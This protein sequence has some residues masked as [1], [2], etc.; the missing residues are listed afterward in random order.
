[1]GQVQA[2]Q[3]PP[4]VDAGDILE[5]RNRFVLADLPDNCALLCHKSECATGPRDLFHIGFCFRPECF[6]Q[7]QP[8]CCF[9]R[10][11]RILGGSRC[12]RLRR[13]GECEMRS[14]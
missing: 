2:F 5:Y 6:D 10:D 3:G 1:M 8:R 13:S 4:L 14:E 9:R 7:R 11:S 12:V